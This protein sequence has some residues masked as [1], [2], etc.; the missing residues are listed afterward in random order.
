MRTTLKDIAERVGVTKALVSLYL[1]NHPLSA[2]I[3]KSTKEKIDRAVRE[4][5]YHPSTMARALKSGRSRTLGLVVGDICSDYFGFLAQSLLNECAKYG[6]QLLIGITRFDPE[7]ERRCLENLIGRQADGIF[8]GLGVFPAEY[9]RSAGLMDYPIFQIHSSHPAFNGIQRDAEEPLKRAVRRFHELGC[10]SMVIPEKTSW[11]G[12]LRAEADRYGMEALGVALDFFSSA[13]DFDRIR[14]MKPDAAVFTSSTF[15][16]SL[17]ASCAR[18]RKKKFPRLFYSYTLPCDCISDP[19]V[20]GVAASD[21]KAIVQQSVRR[22]MQMLEEG[23]KQ[24]RPTEIPFRFLDNAEMKNFCR[25]QFADPFYE[26]FT[27]KLSCQRKG[28]LYE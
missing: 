9:L 16:A 22:M 1:N 18:K 17:L 21:F 14:D 11:A 15:A 25:E 3:A 26:S 6:Y 23:D 19:C 24:I 13:E 7:E 4:L 10:R 28:I 2:K 8:Y 27:M 5:N 12:F 20:I